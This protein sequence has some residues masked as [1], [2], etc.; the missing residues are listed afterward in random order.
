MVIDFIKH[1]YKN[2]KRELFLN[3]KRYIFSRD[4][5]YVLFSGT[6]LGHDGDQRH[7][8]DLYFI[9][10]L[11]SKYKIP[12]ENIILSVDTD[13]LEELK[14]TPTLKNKSDKIYEYVDKVIDISNFKNEY[15][16]DKNKNLVFI[17]S[18][19]GNINGLHISKNDSV[20]N[21]DFFEDIAVKDKDTLLIMSQCF[22]GAFHHLDT[23]KNICV[24]GASEY[25]ESLSMPLLKLLANYNEDKKKWYFKDYI[26]A[27]L[28]NFILNELAFKEEIVLNPFL[29]S[30]FLVLLN[31][32]NHILSRNKHL[33]NIYKNSTS[34]TSNYLSNTYQ[35]IK[36]KG[37]NPSDSEVIMIEGIR[38]TQQSYLLNKILASRFNLLEDISA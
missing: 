29:F 21:S 15:T 19:H 12:K 26:D 13:I 31:P 3:K 8:N 35:H 10:Y 16:R 28:G 6:A 23:R 5:C 14:S 1:L 25:Q 7:L 24:L 2:Y 27:D 11:L 36:L 34:L 18:G 38:I 20:I 4:T 37:P 22:A 30:L 32:S 17:S 33:I 9:L